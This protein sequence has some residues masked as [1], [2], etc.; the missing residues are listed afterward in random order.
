MGVSANSAE[1][2]RL[3]AHSCRQPDLL[4]LDGEKSEALN[5]G[6]FALF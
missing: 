3:A 6:Q 2:I 4:A 1:T 5:S